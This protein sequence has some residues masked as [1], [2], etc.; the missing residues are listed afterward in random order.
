MKVTDVPGQIL[1]VLATIFTEG[2]GAGITFNVTAL[3]VAEAGEAHV[4]LEAKITVTTS[5]LFSVAL[6]NVELFVPTLLPFTCH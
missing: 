6:V 2:V 3:L 5:P 1:F 4:A